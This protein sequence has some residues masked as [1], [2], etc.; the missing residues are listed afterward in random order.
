MESRKKS[1]IKFLFWDTSDVVST[2]S[3]LYFMRMAL[4]GQPLVFNCKSC[5][6]TMAVFKS[7]A[8]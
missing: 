8:L 6:A 4:N 3:C 5:K 1:P 2:F 7:D